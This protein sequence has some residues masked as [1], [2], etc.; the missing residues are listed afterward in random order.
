VYEKEANLDRMPER[1]EFTMG[2]EGLKVI[3]EADNLYGVEGGIRKVYWMAG[4]LV[5]LFFSGMVGYV[6]WRRWTQDHQ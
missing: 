1:F 5:G 2:P 3:A 4:G 6:L